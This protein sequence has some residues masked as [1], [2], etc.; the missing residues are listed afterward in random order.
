MR[1][2]AIPCSWNAV[3]A[4]TV[5]AELQYAVFLSRCI[6]VSSQEVYVCGVK[7]RFG[8]LIQMANYLKLKKYLPLSV[9]YSS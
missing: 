5:M 7:G 6:V 1:K 9:E 4:R 8:V 2:G 3:F